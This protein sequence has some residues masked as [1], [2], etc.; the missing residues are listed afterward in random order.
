M[1]MFLDT[2]TSGLSGSDK[3]IQLAYIVTYASH[4][5]FRYSEYIAW[6]KISIH[7]AAKK[8]HGISTDTL[9]KYGVAPDVVF[10]TFDKLVVLCDSIVAYNAAFDRRMMLSSH[11]SDAINSAVWTCCLD[12][13]RKHKSKIGG[14]VN[15]SG[16]GATKLGNVYKCI[17]GSDMNNAHDAL[18]DVRAMMVIWDF[19]Y[20]K[21]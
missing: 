19:I 6:D 14:S 8:V 11:S 15:M 4:E 7:W 5:V 3:I 10:S 1:L 20:G 12:A 9:R 17:C 16:A 2:E 21:K 18:A 13:V